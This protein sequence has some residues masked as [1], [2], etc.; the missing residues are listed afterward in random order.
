MSASLY[1]PTCLR[2]LRKGFTW[3]EKGKQEVTRGK[4][5]VSMYG[6]GTFSL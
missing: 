3:T 4:K 2:A 5:W 6:A 1:N